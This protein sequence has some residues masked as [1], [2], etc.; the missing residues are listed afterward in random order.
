MDVSQRRLR[1]NAKHSGSAVETCTSTAAPARP[2]PITARGAYLD[3][4]PSVEREDLQNRSGS[5]LPR[6]DDDFESTAPI[7]PVEPAQERKR[8]E[9]NEV[10]RARK[11]PRLAA[12]RD[13]S[14][15]DAARRL[16]CDDDSALGAEARR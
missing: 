16:H 6:R 9:P 14:C 10:A 8:R 15:L 4:P 2:Q 7:E 11:L 12:V 13:A 3:K 1:R 5:A